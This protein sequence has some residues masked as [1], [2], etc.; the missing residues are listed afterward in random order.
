MICVSLIIH[1]YFCFCWCLLTTWRAC[2]QRERDRNTSINMN[3]YIYMKLQ[4]LLEVFCRRCS[5]SL[6]ALTDV[7]YFSSQFVF[8]IFLFAYF[9]K[10]TNKLPF[11]QWKE[12]SAYL[13][14]YLIVVSLMTW[15]K[16]KYFPKPQF[17]L[18]FLF[19]R[20]SVQFFS[21]MTLMNMRFLQKI[22]GLWPY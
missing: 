19:L 5:P 22:V 21:L 1:C 11:I 12:W 17:L 10:Q 4:F 16:T 7:I 6:I 18:Y 14:Y 2:T 3:T 20:T 13:K 8:E 9:W 15:A